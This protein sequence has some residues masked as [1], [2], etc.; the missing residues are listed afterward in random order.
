MRSSIRLAAIVVIAALQTACDAPG[1]GPKAEAGKALGAQYV[2]ALER[3]RTRHGR[4]PDALRDLSV[5]NV[6]SVD[7][8]AV[9]RADRYGVVFSYVD[10]ASDAYTLEFGYHGPGSNHCLYDRD[11]RPPAWICAGHY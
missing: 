9:R 11:A 2:A 7:P 5:S 10:T 8:E 6:L 1:E 4:Y 3:Y